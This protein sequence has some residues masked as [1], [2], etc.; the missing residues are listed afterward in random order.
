M[1]QLIGDMC[2]DDPKQR[3]QMKDVVTRFREIVNG[4][5][6]LSL[7]CPLLSE[8]DSVVMQAHTIVMHATRHFIWRIKRAHTRRPPKILEDR[9][10]CEV[11]AKL[12][13]IQGAMTDLDSSDFDDVWRA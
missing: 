6:Q 2:Q 12:S 3:P 8:Y 5:G 9:S 4:Q 1:Q 11:R 13:N 7:S 10:V